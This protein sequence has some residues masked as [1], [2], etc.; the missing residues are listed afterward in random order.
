MKITIEV[1]NN[2]TDFILELL[3][4][5]DY[6]TVEALPEELSNEHKRIINE[7]LVEYKKNPDIALDWEDVK[8]EL[9]AKK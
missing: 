4:N 5:F 9:G 7:R 1:E 3:Q 2:K 8:K 6:V